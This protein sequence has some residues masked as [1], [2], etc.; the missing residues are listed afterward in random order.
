M[1]QY[2]SP[3]SGKREEKIIVGAWE[4][5]NYKTKKIPKITRVDEVDPSVE[6]EQAEPE[7]WK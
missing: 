1:E 6:S 2:L 7:Q 3:I 5:E 4:K